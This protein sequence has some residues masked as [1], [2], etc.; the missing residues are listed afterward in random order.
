MYQIFKYIGQTVTLLCGESSQYQV[1]AII[2]VAYQYLIT[3]RWRERDSREGS[4]WQQ[5]RI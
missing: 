5:L 3:A 4:K 1:H 2:H